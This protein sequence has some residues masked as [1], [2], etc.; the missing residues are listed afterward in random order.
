MDRMVAFEGNTG[1][2]IQYG[3]ARIASLLKKGGQVDDG[4]E[5]MLEEPQER[6]LA[7]QLLQYNT[8]LQETVHN[9]EPHRL[10]TWL[11]ELTELF[12]SFY[13]SCPVLKVENEAIKQSR[14]R[15]TKITRRVIVD[16]LDV[17][18]IESPQQ[19]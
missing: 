10:C 15:L 9:L 8:V 17:L 12:N 2:Y 1:P 3:A 6:H 13:Q 16:A 19:M 14:L 4:A 11:F 18:G 5:I 7:L